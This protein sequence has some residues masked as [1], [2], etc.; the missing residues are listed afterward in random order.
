MFFVVIY[1][2]RYYKFFLLIS[3]QHYKNLFYEM[4]KILK[5]FKFFLVQCL[6]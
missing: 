3:T 4:T 1:Q 2:K 5:T 6:N